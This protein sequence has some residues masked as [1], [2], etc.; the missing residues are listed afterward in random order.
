MRYTHFFFALD[1]DPPFSLVAA[2][3]EFCFPAG[4]V[5]GSSL[6][7]AA[8]GSGLGAGASDCEVVQFADAPKLVV[9]GPGGAA[10]LVLAYGALD[11]ASK[12][13][14]LPLASAAA[15]LRRLDQ[16]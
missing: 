12:A 10:S 7:F 8:E 15:L 3:A 13:L 11:C 2:S 4:R 9:D 14:R 1:Q 6:A 16:P 5:G